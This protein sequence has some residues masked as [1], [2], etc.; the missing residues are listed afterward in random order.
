MM[1]GMAGT[2][3]MQQTGAIRLTP[4]RWASGMHP[5]PARR[6]DSAHLPRVIRAQ[7]PD[8]AGDAQ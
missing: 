2:G 7:T 4:P 6:G 5:V 1:M 8:P 3:Q